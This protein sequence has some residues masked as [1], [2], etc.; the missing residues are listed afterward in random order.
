MALVAQV[1]ESKVICRDLRRELVFVHHAAPWR[2]GHALW[3]NLCSCCLSRRNGLCQ[4]FL[5]ASGTMDQVNE[6]LLLKGRLR[7]QL[8]LA[9]VG[10]KGLGQVPPGRTSISKP[11]T[12][13][14]AGRGRH[15]GWR[16]V[17]SLHCGSDW[18]LVW[19]LYAGLLCFLPAGSFLLP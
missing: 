10:L 16:R 15:R 4:P 14:L 9:A 7:T 6:E 2:A 13:L 19:V 5:I 1:V 18:C 8:C 12:E 3:R 11:V 17:N